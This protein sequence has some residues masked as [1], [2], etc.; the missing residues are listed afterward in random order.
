M[1]ENIAVS[2]MFEHLVRRSEVAGD[3]IRDRTDRTSQKV[4]KVIKCKHELELLCHSLKKQKVIRS[5]SRFNSV[6]EPILYSK[7]KFD[8]VKSQEQR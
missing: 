6:G 1:V 2:I 5:E 7:G 3:D 8:L 4:D